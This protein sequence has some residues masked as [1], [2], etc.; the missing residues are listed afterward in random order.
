M[1]L[2]EVCNILRSLPMQPDTAAQVHAAAM[3]ALRA[4]G[5]QVHP[6]FYLQ[7]GN[8]GG[9]ID[10]AVC[11]AGKWTAIELDARKPR[12]NSIRKLSAFAGTRVIGLRGVDGPAPEGIDAIVSI[13]VRLSSAV[14]HADKRTVSKFRGGYQ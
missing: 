14:E 11:K 1:S 4:A 5:Y 7:Y 9:R 10:I 2:Q 12:Q 6:E 3:I 8:K 13:P